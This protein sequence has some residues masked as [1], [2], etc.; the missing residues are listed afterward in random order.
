MDNNV[1]SII[2][3]LM[4]IGFLVFLNDNELV[5]KRIKR[6]LILLNA[7][8]FVELLFDNFAL[9]FNGSSPDLVWFMKCIKAMEFIIA[10]TIPAFLCYVIVRRKFWERMKYVF[11]A[12]I[13]LNTILQIGS[14]F[15]SWMFI[16]DD[17]AFYNRS[18]GTWIY[19][20]FLLVEIILVVYSSF[21]TYIQNYHR[22][23][24]I[25]YIAFFVIVRCC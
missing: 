24:S 8:L 1:I 19:L 20:F 25:T 7:S 11:Y 16:V 2:C 4:Q 10:M 18:F 23:N 13:G 15:N 9:R 6:A 5:N 14:V 17:K 21:E 22:L 12:I 3:V